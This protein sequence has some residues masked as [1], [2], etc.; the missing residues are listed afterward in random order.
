MTL[1]NKYP[2]L[3]CLLCCLLT[4]AQANERPVTE[5]SFVRLIYNGA[6]GDSR[7]LVDWPEAEQHFTKGVSRL[8]RVNTS[9]EGVLLPLD[10]PELFDYPWA[11]VVESGFMHINSEESENLRE[12]LLRGGFLMV[13]DFHGAY[14]WATFE[15]AIKQVFPDRPIVELENDDEVFHMLYDLS[16]RQQIPGIHSIFNNRTWEKGGRHPHWRGIFDDHQRLM[17]AINFNQDLGDAWEHADDAAYPQA[18]SAQAYRLGI[19]YLL[20]AMTH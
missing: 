12:Y 14:E 20:Y 19:N 17:I 18:Y 16:Q 7:A 4:Q 1:R 6:Y 2:L 5:F 8:T 3:I 10:S 15:N 11:Y 9:A 13:D